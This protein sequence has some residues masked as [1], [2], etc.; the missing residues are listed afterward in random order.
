MNALII[1]IILQQT[2]EGWEWEVRD[3]DDHNDFL[4]SELPMPFAAACEEARCA[5]ARLSVLRSGQVT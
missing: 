4:A 2:N 3:H 1:E 5:H